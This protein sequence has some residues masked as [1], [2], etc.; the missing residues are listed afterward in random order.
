MGSDDLTSRAAISRPP[1]V[2]QSGM[3]GA[4]VCEMNAISRRRFA[5][6]LGAGLLATPLLGLLRGVL[7]VEAVGGALGSAAGV[8]EDERRAVPAH[9]VQNVRN[10]ARPDG[11]AHQ[12]AHVLRH[13][14]HLKIHLLVQAGVDDGDRAR[15]EPVFGTAGL[16]GG[17]FLS[18]EKASHLLERA[19]R[20]RES[21]ALESAAAQGFE[22]FQGEGEVAAALGGDDG[23]D[24]IQ[25]DGLD[26]AQRFAS[27]GG[28]Q[29][30]DGFRSSNEDIGGV[31]RES[32]ALTGGG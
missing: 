4:N 15:D 25:H 8:R 10:H 14:H 18:D 22:A 30:V 16:L 21:D 19:L 24:F 11:P 9:L 17:P 2:K 27:V 5:L 29:E 26:G 12:I 32:G 23:V 7:L 6:G 1:G 31:A 13:R 28:E 3:L 20:G